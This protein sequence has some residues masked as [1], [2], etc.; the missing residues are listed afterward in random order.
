LNSKLLSLITPEQLAKELGVRVRSLRLQRNWTR[1]T[2]AS[3]AGVT[4][5]SLK[6]FETSGKAS[7]SLVLMVAHAMDRL[8]D[9]ESLLKPAKARSLAELE[10]TQATSRQRGRK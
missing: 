8:S 4:P 10:K 5:S 1:K 9:F 3:R 2:L 6:R 7:L